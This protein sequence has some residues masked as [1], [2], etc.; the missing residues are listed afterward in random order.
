MSKIPSRGLAW[1]CLLKSRKRSMPLDMEMSLRKYRSNLMFMGPN[2]I[3]SFIEHGLHIVQSFS[4]SHPYEKQLWPHINL[5]AEESVQLA[6]LELSSCEELLAFIKILSDTLSLV[7]HSTPGDHIN[8]RLTKTK[9]TL[10][11]IYCKVANNLRCSRASRLRGLYV[12]IDPQHTAGRDPVDIALGALKGGAVAIQLRDKVQDKGAVLSIAKKIKAICN[13]HQALFIVNDDA[14]IAVL[15]GADGLHVGQMDLSIIEARM[16][17]HPW[18]ILGKSNALVEEALESHYYG[19]D[20]I[21]IG[22]I[23]RTHSKEKTR[24]A[25]LENLRGARKA[26][27]YPLVAIGGINSSNVYEVVRAG[28]D[29]IC[30]MSAVTEVQDPMDAARGISQAIAQAQKECVKKL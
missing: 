20:Y 26:G 8:Q 30:V 13:S 6:D 22:S 3:Q 16:M 1:T 2:A 29:A 15:S 25:G 18:Q 7:S 11:E 28:A 23:Y 4:T 14:D 9:A 12:I 10:A 24:P 19:A 21:A 27:T 5:L 17:L